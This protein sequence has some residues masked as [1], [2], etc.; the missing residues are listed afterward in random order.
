MSDQHYQEQNQGQPYPPADAQYPQYPQQPQYGYSPYDVPP[1]IQKWNWGAFMFSIIWGIGNRTW[2][3]LLCLVP[4]FGTVFMFI[5]GAKGN[6]WAWKAGNYQNVETFKAVQDTWNRAGFVY[7]W[8]FVGILALYLLMFL[9]VAIGL[10]S[11]F[12]SYSF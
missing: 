10:F 8:I 4:C 6:E 2:I 7:F 3:A 5:L 12:N 9:L 11:A 1:E